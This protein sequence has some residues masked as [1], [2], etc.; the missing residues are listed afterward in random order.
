MEISKLERLIRDAYVRMPTMK[1]TA[2]FTGVTVMSEAHQKAFGAFLRA[3]YERAVADGWPTA[4]QNR[5]R[6]ERRAAQRQRPA[7]YGR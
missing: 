2:S 6:I 3:N 5:E 1:A 7:R 4:E